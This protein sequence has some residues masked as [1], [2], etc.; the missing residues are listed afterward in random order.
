M[1]DFK[2]PLTWINGERG[3]GISPLDRGFAYGDG[4]FE[5]C[6][7]DRGSIPLWQQ[8]LKRLS[9]SAEKLSIPFD[10]NLLQLYLKVVFDDLGAASGVLKLTLTRG[11]GGRGYGLPE[12][13]RPNWVVLFTP[14]EIP[15]DSSPCSVRVCRQRLS[16]N[17]SLAGLKHLNRLEN[18]LARA[19]WSDSAIAEGL[20]LDDTGRVIEATSH[21]LF[22]LIDGVWCTPEL[23][24]A[25]VRGVMRQL[26]IEELAPALGVEV[27][28]RAL[29]LEH[30]ASA[31]E[32]MVCNSVR[33]I[34][35]VD[36]VLD[37]DGRELVLFDSAEQGLRLHRAL[38]DWMSKR[39]S[40][41]Q[42]DK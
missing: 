6:R 24:E 7:V 27:A 12:A 28:E 21:N 9:Q 29:S 1:S 13:V 18:I 37:S 36:C 39:G 4:L 32:L 16:R 23:G 40:K 5:T 2:A 11:E 10:I 38:D 3:G 15:M 42:W 30:I 34:R 22:A 17:A 14:G 19:E 35:P 33:A 26:V 41:H 8:H 25:G 20:M 31:R